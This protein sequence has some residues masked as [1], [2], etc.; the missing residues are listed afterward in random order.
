MVSPILR[1]PELDT[2]FKALATVV[3]A[4]FGLVV[5][6]GGPK[7]RD[8]QILSAFLLLIAANLGCE[9]VRSV[10][11]DP[12][13]SFRWFRVATVLAAFDPFVLAWFAA[14]FLGW[15]AKRRRW[16]LA[17]FAIASFLALYAAF[18]L[19]SQP[20][21]SSAYELGRTL[22]TSVVYT[23]LAV[24]L[25]HQVVS[26]KIPRSAWPLVSGLLVAAVPAWINLIEPGYSFLLLDEGLGVRSLVLGTDIGWALLLCV[27]FYV[28]ARRAHGGAPPRFVTTSLLT[29]WLLTIVLNASHGARFLVA[30]GFDVPVDDAVLIGKSAAPIRWLLFGAFASKAVIGSDLLALGLRTRRLAAR[31]LIGLTGVVILGVFFAAL[32]AWTN[33]DEVGFTTLDV[34]LITVIAMS[35]TY[36]GLVDRVA[37]AVYGVPMPGDR[38]ARLEAYRVAVIS[39]TTQGRYPARDAELARLRT[40]LEID[41]GT[42]SVL[43]R[44]ADADRDAPLVTG[45]L[46]ASRYRITG[47]AGRG[48]SGRTF[49]GRDELLHRD[50]AIKEVLSD[51]E[52]VLREAR[53]AAS[54][55]HPAIV[56]IYDILPRRGA[57]LLVQEFVAGPTLASILAERALA[58]NE[59]ELLLEKVAEGVGAIHHQRIVHGDVKP[60]NILVESD[61]SPKIVDFGIARCVEGV[62]R[63]VGDA[64]KA[65]GTPGFIAPEVLCGE[66]G[67]QAADVFAL[68][69]LGRMMVAHPN[70]GLARLFD[71]ATSQNPE[72]RPADALEFLAALRLARSSNK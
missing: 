27:G 31:V 52:S 3:T 33:V 60:D 18:A 44:S 6:L 59:G 5:F 72:D 49:L 1:V 39:A 14:V 20:S 11:V 17:P 15:D 29:A 40:E 16:L 36:R 54:L 13:V 23:S 4:S 25:V 37:H 2:Y 19:K 55:R 47:L 65:R 41:A 61:G 67:T 57:L 26:R 35:Q 66:R 50:V 70:P 69:V 43:E 22:Y 21:Y 28:V 38:A 34:V 51:D 8:V 30:A 10:V 42:A 46:L 62:T 48:A 24:I 68:G 9:T 71:R 56:S 7:R 32:A 64:W 63:D 45:E 58:A 12:D 53:L